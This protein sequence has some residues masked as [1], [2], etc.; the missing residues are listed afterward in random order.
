MSQSSLSRFTPSFILLTKIPCLDLPIPFEHVITGRLSSCSNVGWLLTGVLG[1]LDDMVTNS[2]LRL[3]LTVAQW[4][5]HVEWSS[6]N[7]PPSSKEKMYFAKKGQQPR[8]AFQWSNHLLAV[9]VLM[10]QGPW[11]YLLANSMVEYEAPIV[12]RIQWRHGLAVFL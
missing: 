1:W 10:D 5:N 8:C 9:T 12:V 11:T 6:S 4:S 7:V 3:V 2:P